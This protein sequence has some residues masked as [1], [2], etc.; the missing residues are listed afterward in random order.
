MTTVSNKHSLSERY[1]LKPS[2]G[3]LTLL[4]NSI[5]TIFTIMKTIIHATDFSKNAATAL[6]YAHVLCRKLKARLRIIHV[7]DSTTMSS[8]LGETYFLPKKELSK[9]KNDTLKEYCISILGDDFKK[10]KIDIESIE[11]T[12]VI[13]GI[14][15]KAI[16]LNASIIITGMKGRNALADFFIGSTTKQLIEKA[17]CPVLAVPHNSVLKNI[18]TIVYAS[19]FE[20]EDISAISELADIAKVFNARIKIVHISSENEKNGQNEMEWFKEMV[21]QHLNY[22]ALE[23][24]IYNS[25]DI[26]NFLKIYLEEI[27]ADMVAMLEREKR[28][29]GKKLFHTDLVKKMEQQSLIPLI[30][31]NETNY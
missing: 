3:F 16:K 23:F 20:E 6:K 14:I 21:E 26:F 11:N 9:K 31:F 22:K 1:H 13:K 7:Y 4:Y 8:D 5:K 15:E 19:D 18:K 29:L 17:P 30:S 28:S 24:E 10:T 25:D 27:E 2:K 12:S